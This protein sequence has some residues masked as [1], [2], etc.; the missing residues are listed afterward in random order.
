[1]TEGEESSP[2]PEPASSEEAPPEAAADPPAVTPTAGPATTADD[3]PDSAPPARGRFPLVVLA[4][5]Y[6][7][8]AAAYTRLERGVAAA[9]FVVAAPDFPHSSIASP[10]GLDRGDLVNQAGDVSFVISSLLDR[11]SVP[12]AL[13][14]SVPSPRVGGMGHSARGGQ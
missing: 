9:G 7:A 11:V 12:E 8:S 4:H 2:G 13:R 6:A 5:G 1:G 3:E 14:G 10:D